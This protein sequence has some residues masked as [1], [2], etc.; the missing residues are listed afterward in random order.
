MPVTD[1]SG[2][3][4]VDPDWLQQFLAGHQAGQAFGASQPYAPGG[5]PG[6]YSGGPQG[7][8]PGGG[9]LN[10]QQMTLGAPSMGYPAMTGP[11]GMAQAQGPQQAPQGAQGGPSPLGF[12]LTSNPIANWLKNNVSIGAPNL[13]NAINPDAFHDYAVAKQKLGALF[14]GGGAQASPASTTTA[15]PAP[16]RP[17]TPTPSSAYGGAQAQ[18]MPY[19]GMVDPNGVYAPQGAASSGGANAPLPPRR[20]SFTGKPPGAG[21]PQGNPSQTPPAKGQTP[22]LGN[23]GKRFGTVQYQVPGSGGP[24]SRSP[25]YTTLNLFGGR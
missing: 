18:N 9:L 10:R 7:L 13:A 15:P 14:G 8:M 6:P 1:F 24:L 22:N 25:I 4:D 20:P 2:P 16:A 5:A 12:S 19:P 21:A 23:Y 3:G 11:Q 17:V